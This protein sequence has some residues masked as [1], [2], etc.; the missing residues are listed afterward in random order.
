[1][2]SPPPANSRKRSA[3]SLPN[4]IRWLHIYLSMISFA[5][6]VFFAATGITLNHPDW[7][8]SKREKTNEYTG[9]LPIAW[10]Q[11]EQPTEN[12][13]STSPTPIDR[14]SIVEHFR[15]EHNVRGAVKEFSIEEYEI[16]VGFAGP[17]YAADSLI[18]RDDGS[19]TITETLFGTLAI[20]NDLH[21]GRDTGKAWSWVIDLTAVIMLIVSISGFYLLLK[22]RNRKTSGIVTCTIGGL[23]VLIVFI[24]WVP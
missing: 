16:V 2:E 6:L 10:I 15:S 19:Y 8:Y 7:F 9:N 1:M 4:P 18:E 20:L 24:L 12:S 13:A 22:L 17:G 11:T 14:L 23:I 5:A 21:K 3:K